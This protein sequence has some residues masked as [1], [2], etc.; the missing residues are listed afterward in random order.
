MSGSQINYR[1]NY[2]QHPSLTKINGNPACTRLAK[3][4]KE[5]KPNGKSIQS[6]LGG[7]NQGHLGLVSSV[8][9]YYKRVSPGV[10]LA[11]L[12][13]PVLP[14]L[15]N[16]MTAQIAEARQQYADKM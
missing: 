6:T 14:N 4:E 12:V 13:L 16:R 1:E 7:G 15:T 2:F 11:Q 5:C 9:A 8:L 10:P 3:L